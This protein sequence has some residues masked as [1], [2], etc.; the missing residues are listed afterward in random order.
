[1]KSIYKILVVLTLIIFTSGFAIHGQIPVVTLNY[2]G[3]G[4]TS[5][6]NFTVPLVISGNVNVSTFTF[7]INYDSDFITY[8]STSPGSGFS[9]VN[10]Y[11]SVIND[12]TRQL[13]IAWSSTGPPWYVYCGS[14][15]IACNLTFRFNGGSGVLDFIE[16]ACEVSNASWL[17]YPTVT[18]NNGSYAGSYGTL[19]SIAGGG[20]WS[21]AATWQEN[22]GGG[23]QTPSRAFNIVITG[24]EV[25]VTANSK[26][27]SLSINPTGVL[28][29]NAGV[30]L[31]TLS[32]CLIR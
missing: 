4:L 2:N 15:T 17:P 16:S 1:M 21:A 32:D 3:T 24:L 30:T 18:Y 10:G 13:Q 28:K 12:T 11:S 5:G 22:S 26:C 25:T 27:R 7:Y 6:T 23:T 8:V 19:T 9:G 14:S 29:V 31:T 20:T